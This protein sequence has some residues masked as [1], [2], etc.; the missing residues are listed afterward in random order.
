MYLILVILGGSR[1]NRSGDRRAGRADRGSDGAGIRGKGLEARRYGPQRVGQQA[2]VLSLSLLHHPPLP[3]ST[4]T[5][6]PEL[7]PPPP[8]PSSSTASVDEH[9]RSPPTI[10]HVIRLLQHDRNRP[11]N[12]KR[13]TLAQISSP[14]PFC[15]T[16]TPPRSLSL[17]LSPFSAPISHSLSLSL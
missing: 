4:A 2:V 11:H 3:L 8:P 17:S 1:G 15:L 12:P 7:L 14:F 16:L 9:L 10:G 6:S 13:S 5:D